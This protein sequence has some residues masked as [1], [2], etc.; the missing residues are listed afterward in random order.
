MELQYTKK[1][2]VVIL[3]CPTCKKLTLFD[4]LKDCRGKTENGISTRRVSVHCWFCHM[5]WFHIVLATAYYMTLFYNHYL[6]RLDFPD[7]ER[8]LLK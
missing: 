7:A 5:S 4:V 1:D 6:E 2:D 8:G 3:Y